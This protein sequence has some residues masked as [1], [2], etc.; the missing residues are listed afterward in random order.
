MD[1]LRS[2]DD[3]R[4]SFRITASGDR[5]RNPRSRQR[6]CAR[7]DAPLKPVGVFIASNP[8][9]RPIGHAVDKI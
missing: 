2:C 3:G 1:A 7:L 8:M 6:S 9:N 4:N 5:S